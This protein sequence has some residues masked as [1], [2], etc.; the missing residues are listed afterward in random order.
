[1]TNAH[2]D[3]PP[4]PFTGM[5]IDAIEA[6]ARAAVDRLDA[7]GCV[8]ELQ[9]PLATSTVRGPMFTG[10]VKLVEAIAWLVTYRAA[11]LALE[12]QEGRI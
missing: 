7:Y 3:I 1:M 2:N 5:G 6:L 8:I 11:E 9:S 10:R 12:R 4:R